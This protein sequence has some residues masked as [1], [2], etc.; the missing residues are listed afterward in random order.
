MAPTP[1]RKLK[2]QDS[3]LLMDHAA[4]LGVPGYTGDNRIVSFPGKN[5]VRGGRFNRK[6]RSGT[7]FCTFYLQTGNLEMVLLSITWE[8]I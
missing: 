2:E 1:N 3:V 5:P 8:A 7:Y 4:D 6:N